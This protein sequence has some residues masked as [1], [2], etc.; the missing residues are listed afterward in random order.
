MKWKIKNGETKYLLKNALKGL[1]PDDILYRKKMGFSAPMAEWLRG[2]LGQR[3][4]S[5][6]LKSPL[7]ELGFLDRQNISRSFRDHHEGRC[8]NSL[9]LWTLYNLTAW[10]EKWIN[11]HEH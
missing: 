7:L 5:C 6:V 9:H 10:Y 8:D 1:L 11:N 2:E 4:K 3:A